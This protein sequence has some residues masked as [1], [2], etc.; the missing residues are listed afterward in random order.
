MILGT[1]KR[2]LTIKWLI[3]LEKTG[4]REKIL[5][6]AQPDE[7]LVEPTWLIIDQFVTDPKAQFYHR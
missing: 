6:V 3:E 2:G 1:A 7:E 5:L 4:V